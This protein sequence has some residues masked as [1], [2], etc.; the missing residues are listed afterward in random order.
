MTDSPPPLDFS[1]LD[2]LRDERALDARIAAIARDAVIPP[3]PNVFAELAAWTRPALAAAAVLA[4]LA[5]YPLV[6][7]TGGHRPVSTAEILGVP[8]GVVELA[9]SNTPA[10][11][12]DLAEALNTEQSYAR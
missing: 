12:I 3:P 8:S 5:A 6:R 7:A 1:A 11:V 9:R 10:G 2:P 4:A